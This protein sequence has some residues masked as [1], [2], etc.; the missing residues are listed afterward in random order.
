MKT[1]TEKIVVAEFR[2][3]DAADKYFE[4]WVKPETFKGRKVVG[5][6]LVY[7]SISNPNRTRI[8]IEVEI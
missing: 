5:A 4:R 1:K 8:E 2:F 7:K 3:D 6:E